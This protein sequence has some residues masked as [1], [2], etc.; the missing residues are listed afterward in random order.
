MGRL[1]ISDK[2]AIDEMFEPFF[3]EL[4]TVAKDEKL[5]TVI[6][7]TVIA[8]GKRSENLNKKT[9]ELLKEMQLS[10]SESV[11][12]LC[13]DLFKEL[14]GPDIHLILKNK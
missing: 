10:D 6:Y 11:V 12:K 2:K 7:R 4:K 8:L 1:A 5:H 14:T 13:K 3:E 9:V